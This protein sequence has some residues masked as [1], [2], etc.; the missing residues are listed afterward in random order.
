MME[1]SQVL[2]TLEPWVHEYG[3]VAIFLILT[4]Q[5]FGAPVGSENS[6]HWI[7]DRWRIRT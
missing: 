4:L 1:F 7:R 6:I 5:S 2:G 3:A